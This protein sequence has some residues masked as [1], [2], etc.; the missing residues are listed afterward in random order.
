MESLIRYSGPPEIIQARI[1]S[2]EYIARGRC[3]ELRSGEAYEFI[4]KNPSGEGLDL[5]ISPEKI[6]LLSVKYL[7]EGISSVDWS[8]RYYEISFEEYMKLGRPKRLKVN[9]IPKTTRLTPVFR[10]R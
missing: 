2:F 5:S 1:S 3:F 6:R 10:K 7:N 4:R 8:Q 9:I